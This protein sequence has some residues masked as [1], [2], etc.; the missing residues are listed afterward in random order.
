MWKAWKEWGLSIPRGALTGCDQARPQGDGDGPVSQGRVHTRSCTRGHSP[1][2]GPFLL[3]SN[4][5][6]SCCDL[7][8]P[9]PRVPRVGVAAAVSHAVMPAP[10]LGG[11]VAH[12]DEQ[13]GGLLDSQL[14]G[15]GFS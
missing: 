6:L 8:L 1:H 4:L 2:A 3:V 11:H 10:R 14:H 15:S 7:G 12:P 13:E 9:S 5:K